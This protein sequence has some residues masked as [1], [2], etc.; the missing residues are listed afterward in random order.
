M[1]HMS[2]MTCVSHAHTHVQIDR[3]IDRFNQHIS[4]HTWIEAEIGIARV[5]DH[6]RAAK[7]RRERHAKVCSASS[8]L[9]GLGGVRHRYGGSAQYAP[10][11][12]YMHEDREKKSM[13]GER[14]RGSYNEHESTLS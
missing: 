7:P 1:I 8:T 5:K 6:A 4:T 10:D 13:S 2:S 14:A 11:H 9:L 3:Y 12:S